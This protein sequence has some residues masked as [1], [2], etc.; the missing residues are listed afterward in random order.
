MSHDHWEKVKHVFGAAIDLSIAD[1]PAYLDAACGADRALRNEVESLLAQHV[2]DERSG[3]TFRGDTPASA[4]QHED[5][6]GAVIG[7][8]TLIEQI[9]EGGFGSV[10]IAQQDKPVR[11]KVAVKIIKLGMDTRQVI[12]R[13]EAERQAL[14]MM[15]HPGIARVYDAG[16]TPT[17]RPYFVMELVNGRAVTEYCDAEGLD[18]RRRVEVFISICQAIQH[19]HQKGLIHR[20]IKP[21]NVL[22]AKVDDRPAVKVIDFGIAKATGD[23][24]PL[25]TQVTDAKQMIG[26]P[27]YM[28]PEQAGSGLDIDTRTDV[29]S[30]GILLY[31]LLTGATPLDSVR[32]RSAPYEELQRLI[33]DV[34]PPRPSTRVNLLR[35]ASI[36][37]LASSSGGH[38]TPDSSEVRLRTPSLQQAASSHAEGQAL[39][40]VGGDQTD[41]DQISRLRQTDPAKLVRTL[42]GDLDWIVMKAIE[43]D[44]TRRYASVSEFAADLVRYL[45]N[46]PVTA[47]PPG[48]RYR[49]RKFVRR[50]AKILAVVAMV[51][52]AVI[53]GAI[54]T[55]TAMFRAQRAERL[56]TARLGEVEAARDDAEQA[57]LKESAQ[58]EKAEESERAALAE[59]EKRDQIS[60]FL[61]DMLRG[62]G[63]GV[64]RG[65]DTALLQE[66]LEQTEQ[67]IERELKDQP[68]VEGEIRSVIAEVYRDLGMLAQSEDN[69]RLAL[70]ALRRARGE[71]HRDVATAL[72]SLGVLRTDRGDLEDAEKYLNESLAMRRSLFGEENGEVAVTLRYLGELQRLRGSLGPAEERLRD[73]VKMM[74]AYRSD[75]PHHVAGALSGLANVLLDQGKYAE[76][77]SVLRESIEIQRA[78]WS[79]NHPMLARSLSNLATALY[80]TVNHADAEPIA[81]EAL[82]MRRRILG[83][84]HADTASSKGSLS[85][86]LNALGQLEESEQLVR[87][88][89]A[90]L[91]KSFGADSVDVAVPMLNLAAYLRDRGAHEEAAP[92]FEKSISILRERLGPDHPRLAG[93]LSALVA[94]L[95]MTKNYAA[96]EKAGREQMAIEV[97]SIPAD[98]PNAAAT[99]VTL[100]ANITEQ[101]WPL[102]GTDE[103]QTLLKRA[104]EAETFI[105]EGM[106]ARET[107]L[108]P[109]HWVLFNTRTILGAATAAV[110]AT[111]R[112]EADALRKFRDAETL[113]LEGYEGLIARTEEIP[114]QH[115]DFIIGNC[116]GR[117]VH[118]YESWEL[119]DSSEEIVEK[120][121]LW[122]SRIA[123]NHD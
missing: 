105:K 9:G 29:Y 20:D 86:V 13:F 5:R 10:F 2:Q 64:A 108:P 16:A 14:A 77:V 121:R 102:L 80:Y 23:E 30:L 76:A 116:V 72:C 65:R 123:P 98:H 66:I 82:A 46:E 113:L 12:G 1:R 52:V 63:P 70:A 115:R 28:S 40:P 114:P 95:F 120:T 96:A 81:R 54:G 11:R 33:R 36:G 42:R 41:A 117:L 25:H 58:R 59:A 17:G 119:I 103:P 37:L 57:A 21:S 53:V 99:R 111:S 109:G 112:D 38:K 101:I 110:A 24:Q 85:L 89:I 91:E 4:M 60:A 50:H 78:M 68:D 55:A 15:D 51:A 122:R 106:A 48:A 100:G 6:P 83:E 45:H 118:L 94:S 43:K 27:K 84:D 93:A 88:Q 47:G 97:K 26:T 7:P 61:E 31:E 75:E 90:T 22:V 35:D 92:Y 18:I 62:V 49:M 107:Q 19:A 34:E 104:E 74:R 44:R 73:C 32:L 79:D 71:T 56:A 67:R 3:P 39:S 69:Q 87:E 8:Y